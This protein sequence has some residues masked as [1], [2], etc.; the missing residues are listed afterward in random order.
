MS[1]G[2]IRAGSAALMVMAMSQPGTASASGDA[3]ISSQ[4]PSAVRVRTRAGAAGFVAVPDAVS[5]AVIA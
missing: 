2:V 4:C 5:S 3:W 1:S